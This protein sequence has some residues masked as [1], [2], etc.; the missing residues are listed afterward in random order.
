MPLQVMD[1]AGREAASDADADERHDEFAAGLSSSPKS[2]LKAFG[3]AAASFARCASRDVWSVVLA[4]RAGGTDG[5]KSGNGMGCTAYEN[6]HLVWPSCRVVRACRNHAAHLSQPELARHLPSWLAL[7]LALRAI[8][9][10][11]PGRHRTSKGGSAPACTCVYCN[12]TSDSAE[13]PGMTRMHTSESTSC[14][15]DERAPSAAAGSIQ[16]GWILGG[17]GRIYRHCRALCR[18]LHTTT[19]MLLLLGPY[20]KTSAHQGKV[21]CV[22][23]RT[24][25]R[26]RS[27]YE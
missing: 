1:G 13:N 12:P 27:A 6:Q 5:R 16:S 14:G 18:P 8:G 21:T 25:I 20:G 3:I 15:E 11:G 19:P 4:G 22:P 2:S 17:G 7:A 9:R 26:R 24:E 23:T 10:E